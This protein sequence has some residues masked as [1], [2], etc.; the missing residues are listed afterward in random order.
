MNDLNSKNDRMTFAYT[1]FQSWEAR[2]ATLK[3]SLT[4]LFVSNMIPQF[5]VV[6]LL[7]EKRETE[8]FQIKINALLQLTSSLKISEEV[9]ASWYD[10]SFDELEEE[11]LVYGDKFLEEYHSVLNDVNELDD[12]IESLKSQKS[13]FIQFTLIVQTI[14]TLLTSFSKD[15][16]DT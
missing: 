2:G 6:Q 10:L 11:K 1:E 13:R 4:S 12:E 3:A 15:K 14:G 8:Y 5:D 16:T 9:K 7:I